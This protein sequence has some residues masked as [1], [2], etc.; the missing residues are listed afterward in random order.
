MFVLYKRGD[1]VKKRLTNAQKMKITKVLSK[2]KGIYECEWCDN[3][4][5]V[6]KDTFLAEDLEY[7]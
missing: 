5:N 2:D 4:N 7:Y 3:E 6:I 1:F